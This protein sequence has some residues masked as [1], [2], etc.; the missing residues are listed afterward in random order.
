MSP[1]EVLILVSA[2]GAA[3][4]ALNAWGLWRTTRAV[5]DVRHPGLLLTGSFVLRTLVTVTPVILLGEGEP[6]RLIAGLASFVMIRLLAVH[7]IAGMPRPRMRVGR[8]KA[9]S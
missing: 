9:T 5:P 1:P 3:G 6:D 4:G 8:R 2:T 7:A